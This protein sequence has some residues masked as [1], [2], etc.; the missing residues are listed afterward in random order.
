ML[1]R[2]LEAHG[3]R[4]NLLNWLSD[5]TKGRAQRV[6]LNGINS[7][8]ADVL[9]S[10]VQGSVLGPVLFTIFINDIDT[11]I[12]DPRTKM[13]KYADDSKFGRPIRSETD[14]L[15][16][17][18]AIDNVCRWAQKWGME[19]HPE[20]TH[21]LHFGHGNPEF[22]YSLNVRKYRRLSQRGIWVL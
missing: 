17:Q 7:S 9:S 16:L 21:V 14:A 20:K 18:S 5:W 10:V 8:W 19:I 11:V 12:T 3:I 13:F 1:L 22:E 6:V 15:S 4:G 2:K